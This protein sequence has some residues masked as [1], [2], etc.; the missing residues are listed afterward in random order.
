MY[1]PACG[2]DMSAVLETR[3]GVAS[4]RRRR[5]CLHCGE[6]YTTI[7]TVLTL[8]QV[9]SLSLPKEKDTTPAKA[10]PP[11]RVAR[12]RDDLSWLNEDENYLPE[13]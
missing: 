10:S 9:T 2:S 7:E 11:P 5:R 8:W 4:V 3:K 13:V 6:R 1:C 12:G